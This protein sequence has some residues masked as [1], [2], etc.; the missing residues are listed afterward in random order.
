MM[1]AKLYLAFDIGGTNIKY[2][3]IRE[4]GS[5]LLHSL[6]R[7]RIREAGVQAMLGDLV[8]IAQ[9]LQTEYKLSAIGISTSGVVDVGSGE[10]LRAAVTFPGYKGCN[11]KKLQEK[12]TG[13]PCSI[14][15]D[16]NCA[17]LGEYYFGAAQGKDIVCC[18][19]IGTGIGGAT[20]L[21]G[22]MFYGHNYFACEVGQFPVT[23]GTLEP[24]ATTRAL[25]ER[26]AKAKNLSAKTLEG[27][28]IFDLALAGDAVAQASI[29]TMVDA[30]AQGLVYLLY[31]INP[32][33]IVLGG[34]VVAQEE[35]LRPRLMAKL[36]QL[37]VPELLEASEIA[38]SKLENKAGMLGAVSSYIKA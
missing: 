8:S 38:F 35:Y 33:V 28:Q 36:K 29:D 18:L 7:N 22:K 26:V 17:A 25:I 23:G 11:P 2:G 37:V 16:V 10:L 21:N 30:L 1:E 15:N 13:L 3:I 4:D 9:R 34:A 6:L 24:L 27:Q 32:Q 31:A 19:A 5:F 14:D 20:L 12:A